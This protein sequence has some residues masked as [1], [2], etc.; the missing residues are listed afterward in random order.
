M[1]ADSELPQHPSGEAHKAEARQE[2]PDLRPDPR[3]HRESAEEAIKLATRWLRE[4]RRMQIKA[5]RM[6]TAAVAMQEL[7][8]LERHTRRQCLISDYSNPTLILLDPYLLAASDIPTILAI[9]VDAALQ[10]TGADMGNAQL[11]D[12]SLGAFDVEAQRGFEQPFLEF[13]ASVNEGQAACGMALA[14]AERVIVEDVEK[15]P[16]FVGTPAL[17]VMLEARARAVQSI[18]LLGSS[19][20][21][22]GVLSTHYHQPRYPTE[23]VLHLLELTARVTARWIER[24]SSPTGSEPL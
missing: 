14:C 2:S 13:F 20:Q 9:A 1:K 16:I 23:S 7:L 15:S 17:D 4:S 5:V 6:R 24:K 10:L 18:P 19:G 3:R 12:P 11:F 8:E 21:M 22:L